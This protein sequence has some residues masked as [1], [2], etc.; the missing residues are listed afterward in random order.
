MPR[1]TT[2]RT[3]RD[4]GWVDLSREAKKARPRSPATGFLISLEAHKS[5]QYSTAPQ[6]ADPRRLRS[7]FSRSRTLLVAIISR[8]STEAVLPEW[9]TASEVLV[10]SH[11]LACIGVRK[12]LLSS[13]TRKPH[14]ES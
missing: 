9:Q 2:G 5:E 1:W 11:M 12:A 4:L 3:R 8:R 6:S 10:C 13:Q 14:C 7:S